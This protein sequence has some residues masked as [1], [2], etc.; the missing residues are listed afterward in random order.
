MQIA[1]H[2][3]LHSDGSH[4]MTEHLQTV[5]RPA[6]A[7]FG[8]RV[9]RVDAH[10]SGNDDIQCTLEARLV[11]LDPVVVKDQSDNAHQAIAGAVNKLKRAVGTALAKQDPRGHRL[12]PMVAGDPASTESDA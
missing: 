7:R 4:P 11:G 2:S 9:L 6:L 8:E 12:Q 10:L 1:V 5:V 3:S